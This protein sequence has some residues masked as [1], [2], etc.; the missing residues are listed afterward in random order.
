MSESTSEQKKF[1]EAKDLLKEF[2]E[3]PSLLHTMVGKKYTEQVK[4]FKEMEKSYA[5]VRISVQQLVEEYEKTLP[6]GHEPIVIKMPAIEKPKTEAQRKKETEEVSIPA[7]DTE[8]SPGYAMSWVKE[9]MTFIESCKRSFEQTKD[10]FNKKYDDVR[11]QSDEKMIA[12]LIHIMHL[13]QHPEDAKNLLF[14]QELRRDGDARFLSMM[15]NNFN[16]IHS[17]QGVLDEAIQYFELELA[18][19]DPITSV[20]DSTYAVLIK[21]YQQVMQNDIDDITSGTDRISRTKWLMKILEVYV[22]QKK[23]LESYRYHMQKLNE[24][25]LNLNYIYNRQQN[26]WCRAHTLFVLLLNKIYG[27]INK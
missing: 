13:F 18:K 21:I 1:P 14:V 11:K 27:R 23:L 15:E 5:A 25:M 10:A 8:F 7:L 12:Q 22:E 19:L 24:H 20:I 26:L 2:S 17:A 6:A 4:Y 3:L 16:F 9:T